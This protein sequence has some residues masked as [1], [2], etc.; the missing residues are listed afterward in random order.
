LNLTII[1]WIAI[2]FIVNYVIGQLYYLW[3]I[4]KSVTPK[5]NSKKLPKL[6]IIIPMK[7]EESNIKATLDSLLAQDY[8]G[9]FEVIC[10]NDRSTDNT[11]QIV[12]SFI[13]DYEQIKLFEIP[14]DSKVVN[15]PK[16]RALEKG[17]KNASGEIFFTLDADC[18]PPTAWLSSMTLH[19]QNGADIVQ[20]P[21]RI[22]SS[23]KLIH[24]YQ[25]IDTLSFTLI[26]AAFFNHKTPMLASA[27]SLAYRKSLYE[28]AHGFEGLEHLESGDDDM[29]VQKMSKHT[30]N[31][32]YNADPEAQVGTQPVNHWGELFTQ[33]ARWASNSTS[34]PSLRYTGYLLG[35]YSYF[36][37][38][39]LSPIFLASGLINLESFLILL[40]SKFIPDFIL[41]SAGTRLLKCTHLIKHIF[42][43]EF[44]QVPLTVWAVPAGY[45]KW[46]KW[47]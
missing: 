36:W 10:I 15:S 28:K 4:L 24:S 11:A 33:R 45:F 25:S 22:I 9:E 3:G 30:T 12:N 31:V 37:L 23:S 29:L 26:E 20:G 35:V 38:I 19:F 46:Y 43:A 13:Q 14:T 1:Q 5:P 39:A 7:D 2:P 42:W 34:Y 21:K 16:K 27:P 47:K 40:A 17:F 32:I 44:I 6:S 41:L 8:Q 18:V